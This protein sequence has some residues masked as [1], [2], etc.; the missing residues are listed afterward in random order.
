MGCPII[1]SAG[2]LMTR[3]RCEKI[4]FQAG[5]LFV[6][7]QFE[8]DKLRRYPHRW[9]HRGAI[10]LLSLFAMDNGDPARGRHRS[11]HRLLVYELCRISYN[12]VT[13]ISKSINIIILQSG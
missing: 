4:I 2:A 6:R 1:R 5:C 13:P 12:K 8:Q 3:H 10:S 9:H 7:A 11:W